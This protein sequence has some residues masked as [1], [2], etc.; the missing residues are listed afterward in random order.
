MLRELTQLEDDLLLDPHTGTR[1]Y[2]Q[3]LAL[4]YLLS[5]LRGELGRQACHQLDCHYFVLLVL[6]LGQLIGELGYLLQLGGLEV[7][8]Q[9]GYQVAALLFYLS[10]GAGTYRKEP[11]ARLSSGY[12]RSAR[13]CGGLAGNGL[14]FLK[15]RSSSFCMSS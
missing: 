5:F 4:V 1:V 12:S 10:D 6:A 8:R 11:S 7:V 13:K 15:Y 14:L 9:L 3:K 2:A